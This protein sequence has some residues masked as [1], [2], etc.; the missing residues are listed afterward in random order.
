MSYQQV[1][2]WVRKYNSQVTAGLKDNCG[3]GKDR[4]DMNEVELLAAENKLLKARLERFEI[5]AELKKK[6]TNCKR[7]WL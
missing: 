3:K 5:E 7:I 2:N 4:E 1:Y 6:Y